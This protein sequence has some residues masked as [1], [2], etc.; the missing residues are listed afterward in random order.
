MLCDLVKTT[1]LVSDPVSRNA[2][3]LLDRKKKEQRHKLGDASLRGKWSDM[4]LVWY[5]LGIIF[6]RRIRKTRLG[7]LQ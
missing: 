6:L 2:S 5:L 3:D 7:E 4:V 1:L